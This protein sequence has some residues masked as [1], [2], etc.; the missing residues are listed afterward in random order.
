MSRFTMALHSS[1]LASS[2]VSP[3]T[4]HA[5]PSCLITSSIRRMARTTDPSNSVVSFMIS[6]NLV[7]VDHARTMSMRSGRNESTY[8][9]TSMVS[10]HS[11]TCLPTSLA[12][13]RNLLCTSLLSSLSLTSPM[14]GPASLQT[15]ALTSATHISAS[16]SLKV[17]LKISSVA[18]SSSA[19]VISHATLPFVSTTPSSLTWFIRRST[20][21]R[22]LS[23]SRRIMPLAALAS[24]LAILH[25]SARSR[26]FE[27]AS[28]CNG[29]VSEPAS[30]CLVSMPSSAS[31]RRTSFLN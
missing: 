21:R 31:M 5:V 26:F 27:N 8:S 24:R 13:S 30:G 3:M 15:S 20:R 17:P 18:T 7:P 19:V 16:S 14:S 22:C 4:R 1:N 6:A 11:E 29:S 28:S 25:C 9:L 23:S 12:V 2:S 10:L